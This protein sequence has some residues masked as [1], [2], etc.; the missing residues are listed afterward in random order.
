MNPNAFAGTILNPKPGFV[1]ISDYASIH[2]TQRKKNCGTRISIDTTFFVGNHE[3]HSDRKK[4][5]KNKLPNI[6]INQFVDAGQ[7][8]KEKYAE[9]VSVYSHY[10]S[11]VLKLIKF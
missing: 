7:Y 10:T 11:K 6:G 1:Y 2:N 3:P 4:E 8:E 9:K 5:Y